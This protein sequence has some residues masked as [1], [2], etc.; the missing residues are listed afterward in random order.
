MYF[1]MAAGCSGMHKAWY[2]GDETVLWT[3]GLES[4]EKQLRVCSAACFLGF[5]HPEGFVYSCNMASFL[6]FSYQNS[7]H[8]LL[9]IMNCA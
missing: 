2:T 1:N 9:K 3:P 5:Y 6:G 4:A 7:Q 8:K